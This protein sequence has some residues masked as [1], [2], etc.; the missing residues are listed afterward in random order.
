MQFMART[1][2]IPDDL[3]TMI[4]LVLEVPGGGRGLLPPSTRAELR[5]ASILRTIPERSG[6]IARRKAKG[7]SCEG[8]LA[9]DPAIYF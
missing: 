6:Q 7:S 2:W 9:F 3:R 5:V 8:P 4:E 1:D